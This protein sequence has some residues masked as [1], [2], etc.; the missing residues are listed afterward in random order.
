LRALFTAAQN[1]RGR[2]RILLR[3]I[4]SGIWIPFWA[5]GVINGVGHYWG[6]RNY[7]VEDASTNIVPWGILI[8]GEEFHKNHHAYPSSAKLSS[9]WYEFDIGWMYIQLLEMLGQAAVR[10]IAPVPRFSPG[11][12]ECD[13]D[14]V[15]AIIT[16]R[17]YVL[18][19]YTCSVKDACR[20]EIRRLKQTAAACEWRE[21]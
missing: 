15:K 20:Q 18:A 14:T 2:V 7:P 21:H 5:A 3:M 11:K 13:A 6:Y 17:Y 8:G 4:F 19:Q 9:A 10:R 16:H 12:T 1:A